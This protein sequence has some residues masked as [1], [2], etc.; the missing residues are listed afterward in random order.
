VYVDGVSR[1]KVAK[2]MRKLDVGEV[3][4][5]EMELSGESGHVVASREVNRASVH[6]R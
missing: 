2:T 3:E 4:Q 5:E 1:V 6:V